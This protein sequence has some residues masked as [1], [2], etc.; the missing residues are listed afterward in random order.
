MNSMP[1]HQKHPK[2]TRPKGGKWARNEVSLVGAPCGVIR[3]L[4]EKIASE[5]APFRCVFVD[6][7]HQHDEDNLELEIWT[8]NGTSA[9][10]TKQSGNQFD[11]QFLFA[12][13]DLAIV[14]GNHFD[15]EA[16]IIILDD[17]K[18]ESLERKV[19]RLKNVVA[20]IEHESTQIPQFLSDSEAPRFSTQQ[21]TA[22]S[23][24]IRSLFLKP[25]PVFGLV[26][27][28]G[29]ST[30]M[31]QDKSL[32]KYHG[33]PQREYMQELLSSHC[34]EVFSSCRPDQEE[35]FSSLNPLTD[36][37]IGMGPTGAIISAFM[38]NPNVAWMV[39]AIDLPYVDDNCIKEL[40]ENRDPSKFATAFNN[41]ETG[42]PDPLL[43]IWEPKCYDRLLKFLAKGYSCPRKVLI[44]SDISLKN[45]SNQEWLKNVNTPENLS[46]IQIDNLSQ[47]K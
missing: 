26:L 11:A 20:I 38:S 32:L 17:R 4:A 14:N 22:I 40:V 1:K 18:Q 37:V 46:E 33:K 29:R 23:S 24:E 42:F 25:C 36:K 39:A 16:Q 7:S 41:L 31:K 8:K 28:G 19:D 6:E 2:L 27:A 45:P 21:V 13:Y 12:E 43:T 10:Y 5:L 35:D 47:T 15:C 30:R 44:N 34:T 9:E 3:D